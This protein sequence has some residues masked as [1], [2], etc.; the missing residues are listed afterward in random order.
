[1]GQGA[2][3]PFRRRRH[4]RPD[5]QAAGLSLLVAHRPVRFRAP[6]VIPGFGLTLGLTLAYLGLIVLAPLAALVLKTA[7]L[8]W[9]E[10]WSL[11]ADPRTL[12]ALRL[13]FSAAL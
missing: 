10:F 12:T 7:S 11:L 1:M 9:S 3:D 4:L 8:G 13:S 6:S 2:A 5:L